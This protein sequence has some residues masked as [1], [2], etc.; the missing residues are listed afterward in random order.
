[1]VTSDEKKKTLYTVLIWGF[2]SKVN[3]QN[4]KIGTL[5]IGFILREE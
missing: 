5:K 1:M 4:K 3:L 2:K